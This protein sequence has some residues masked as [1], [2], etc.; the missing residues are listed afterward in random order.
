VIT[1][2]SGPWPPGEEPLL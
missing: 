2:A 1:E